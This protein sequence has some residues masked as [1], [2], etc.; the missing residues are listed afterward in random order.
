MITTGITSVKLNNEDIELVQQGGG[1]G[2]VEVLGMLATWHW[3]EW[4]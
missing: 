4:Q 2:N 3:G 1:N